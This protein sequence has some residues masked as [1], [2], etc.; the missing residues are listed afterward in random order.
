MGRV[1]CRHRAARCHP[2]ALYTRSTVRP[3]TDGALAQI[4]SF[5]PTDRTILRPNG[6]RVRRGRV[7]ANEGLRGNLHGATNVQIL[8][9]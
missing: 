9:N 2:P 1:G 6:K 3:S 7:S 4:V 8:N 5:P